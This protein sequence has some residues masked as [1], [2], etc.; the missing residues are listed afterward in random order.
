LKIEP[1]EAR[2]ISL[3]IPNGLESRE[4]EKCFEEVDGLLRVKDFEGATEA[5]DQ[6]ILRPIMDSKYEAQRRHLTQA[7]LRMRKARRSR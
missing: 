6:L 7:L 5:V 2:K 1:S 4:I 3:L